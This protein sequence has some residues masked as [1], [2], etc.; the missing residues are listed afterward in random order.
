MTRQSRDIFSSAT[1]LR[2][3]ALPA[4]TG[5]GAVI[6]NGIHAAS[7]PVFFAGAVIGS[8]PVSML[9][10]AAWGLNRAK[11]TLMKPENVT[12]QAG[13]NAAIRGQRSA[14]SSHLAQHNP[15]AT[16]KCRDCGDVKPLSAFHRHASSKDGRLSVCKL[17]RSR[18]GRAARKHG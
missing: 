13:A 10:L 18:S 11:E 2:L 8:V 17:C 14:A 15:S 12:S 3:A 1:L 4:V 7:W 16:K 6:G 9:L 5:L